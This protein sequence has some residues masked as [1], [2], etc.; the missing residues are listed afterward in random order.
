[1]KTIK[2]F[3]FLFV[4]FIGMNA[5]AQSN[6]PQKQKMHKVVDESILN[7]DYNKAA[8]EAIDKT[9]DVNVKVAIER[10]VNEAIRED[11]KQK[12]HSNG[13]SSSNSGG[14]SWNSGSSPTYSGGVS[15]SSNSGSSS[16]SQKSDKNSWDPSPSQDQTKS[17]DNQCHASQCEAAKVIKNKK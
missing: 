8:H 7:K 2:L 4:A 10:K 6:D 3:L 1:M 9:K 16:A 14:S 11:A 12:S 15:S 13:G 5:N 17:K